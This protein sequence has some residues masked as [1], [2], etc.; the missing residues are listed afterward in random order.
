MTGKFALLNSDSL[1]ISKKQPRL[2]GKTTGSIRI[3]SGIERALKV[4]DILSI[5]LDQVD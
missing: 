5:S 3:T 2:S 4:K 1:N